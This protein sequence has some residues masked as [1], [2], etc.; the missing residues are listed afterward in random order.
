MGEDSPVRLRADM[1]VHTCF[2]GWR[3]LRIIHPRDSYSEPAEVYR[4]ALARGMD[5]VVVS[6]H[7]SIEGALRL[8]EEPGVDPARVIVGEELECTF[9]GTGQWVHVNVYG[10]T[11]ADHDRLRSLKGDVRDAVAFCRERGLLH[12]FNHPF[13][14]FLYQKTP[15]RYA[16]DIFSLF[17]HVEGLNGSLP[18]IQNRAVAALCDLGSRSGYPLVRV[19]GSDAHTLARVG[20]AWTEARASDARSFLDEVKVGRCA[21]GGEC[22]STPGLVG[23]VYRNVGT[24][25]ARLYTGRGE[26][27]DFVGYAVDLLCATACLPFAVGGLPAALTLA[28]R[29]RQK[30]VSAGVIGTLAR[31]E[32]PRGW[33]GGELDPESEPCAREA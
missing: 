20:G 3:H 14:S 28:S 12:V 22:V 6:D 5:L 19:G 15:I 32:L 4:R 23:E 31:A 29:V 13:Q 18:E 27:R 1:H 8:L 9:P 2:S 11:G 16:A 7:E 21:I 24:Y 30:C 26:C 10:L 25:Y 33:A 17:T